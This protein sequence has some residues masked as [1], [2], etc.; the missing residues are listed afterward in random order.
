MRYVFRW[1]LAT[2]RKSG[3]AHTIQLN[4]SLSNAEKLKRR[5]LLAEAFS[6]AVVQ[7]AGL[8]KV[9]EMNEL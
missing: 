4:N 5:R 3:S 7:K 2:V 8:S 1:C 6:G 9:R